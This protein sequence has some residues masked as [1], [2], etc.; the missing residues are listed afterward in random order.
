ML[1]GNS[2]RKSVIIKALPLSHYLQITIFSLESSFAEMFWNDDSFSSVYFFS[3]FLDNVGHRRGKWKGQSSVGRTICTAVQNTSC[4]CCQKWRGCP[5][6]H[7]SSQGLHF[8]VIQFLWFL[9]WLVFGFARYS[10]GHCCIK[11]I[12]MP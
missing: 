2:S 5:V 8:V 11:Y 4:R 6:H 9:I 10:Y 1:N 3:C 7:Q 12:S